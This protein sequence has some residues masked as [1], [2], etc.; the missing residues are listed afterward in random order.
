MSQ[1]IRDPLTLYGDNPFYTVLACS[2]PCNSSIQNMVQTCILSFSYEICEMKSPSLPP[3]IFRK[4][5]FLNIKMHFKMHFDKFG[6]FFEDFFR[7]LLI[8]TEEFKINI[9]FD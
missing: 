8:Q 2:N 1:Q 7:I 6:G 4:Q 9:P 5:N 3:N